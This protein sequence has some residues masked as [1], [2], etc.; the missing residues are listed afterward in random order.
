MAALTIQTISQAGLEATFAA[1][2]V[3]DTMKVDSSE[4]H[5]FHVKNDGVGDVTATI[6]AVELSKIVPGVGVVTIP[7]IV[8]VI[9]AGEERMIGP[10]PGA[11]Q[12]AGGI[13]TLALSGVTSVTV[14]ALYLAPAT[15]NA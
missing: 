13:V 5:F 1:S 8:E 4:R 3:S 10:F 11:Y 9:T 7:D 2:S 14:A 15:N 12:S 6:A